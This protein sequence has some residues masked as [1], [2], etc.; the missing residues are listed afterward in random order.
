MPQADKS[1]RK[2]TADKTD[3]NIWRLRRKIIACTL[4]YFI[5]QAARC[6][7]VINRGH[8]TLRSKGS[9]AQ[10]GNQAVLINVDHSPYPI[11]RSFFLSIDVG[12]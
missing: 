2:H 9:A 3:K 6:A 4:L 8:G 1:I 10:F 12:T 5:H 7:T 11:S